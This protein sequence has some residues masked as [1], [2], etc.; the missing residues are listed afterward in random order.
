MLRSTACRPNYHSIRST[1][2]LFDMHDSIATIAS[3]AF[4]TVKELP[5]SLPGPSSYSF[6]DALSDAG[7]YIAKD[8]NPQAVGRPAH[9]HNTLYL[10]ESGMS[11]KRWLGLSSELHGSFHTPSHGLE[12]HQF[13]LHSPKLSS[14]SNT[15]IQCCARLAEREFP[16]SA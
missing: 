1:K 10:W 3:T 16:R 5:T 6:V 15:R 7:V 13:Y 12:L 14:I 11:Y 4:L 8:H 2:R 9:E